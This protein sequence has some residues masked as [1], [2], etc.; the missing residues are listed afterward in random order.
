MSSNLVTTPRQ[1]TARL[2][3][4]RLAVLAVVI[5]LTGPSISTH[6]ETF[7]L[8][9]KIPLGTVAG[10]IDHLAFDA[11]KSRLFIAELGNGSVSI[12][13]VTARSV[14]HRISGLREP[15]GVAYV[16]GRDLLIVASG[17]T[18]DVT[19]YRAADF[20][21]VWTASLGRDADN[22]RIDPGTGEIMVGYGSSL[23]VLDLEGHKMREVPLAGH[24]E[25]FQLTDSRIYVNVPSVRQIAAIGS[26]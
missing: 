8:E 24:P 1:W 12:V 6:S 3:A 10:R 13:D 15:Q 20:R 19:G 18:G 23:A 22:I 4:I 25:A 9:G 11:A 5:P 17:G 16:P 2:L 14:L 7:R 26:S 21:V